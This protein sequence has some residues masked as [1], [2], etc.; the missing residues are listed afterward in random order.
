MSRMR[1][2]RR[3]AVLFAAMVGC[4]VWLLG[5]TSTNNL[6][7]TLP[8]TSSQF[9]LD[10]KVVGAVADAPVVYM[11]EQRARPAYRIFSFDPATGTEETVFTVPTD[12]IIYGIDLS[13]DG[14][15]LAVAYTPDHTLG[16]S[17]MWAVDVASGEL[18][19]ISPVETG[20]YLT[21]PEW[22]ADGDTVLATRVDRSGGD[23][24]LDVVEVGSDGS[25]TALIEDAIDPLVVA[26]NLYY[27]EVDPK[28]SA[29]HAVGLLDS[30][31][32]ERKSIASSALDLDHLV[33]GDT[34]EDVAVA[35]L[36]SEDTSGGLTL[37]SS[38]AAHGNHVLPST[39]WNVTAASPTDLPSSTVYDADRA[40][41]SL[42]YVTKE[43]L[44]IA[45]GTE[46]NVISSRA[47]R[48]ITA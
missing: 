31:T 22:S 46:V 17:G 6:P 7:T 19:E 30:A 13:A 29:R 25:V 8:D 26:G 9:T 33:A 4:T 37:G 35:V 24:V 3:L 40:G 42:V 41:K 44:T 28:T 5:F 15:T 47:L 18:S 43:G 11:V 1:G 20:V 34:G 36:D 2:T 14:S 39:W 23:E 12:A 27:L 38:A 48:F 32:G 45:G 10:L 16:G 21:D